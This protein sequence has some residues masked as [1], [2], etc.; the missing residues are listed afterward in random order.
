MLLCCEVNKLEEYILETFSDFHNLVDEQR[1][2]HSIYRGVADESYELISRFGRA[3]IKNQ[4]FREKNPDFKYIVDSNKEIGSLSRLKNES[5]PY[6]THR[7][8]NDWEWLS[9]AQHHGL[10]TRLLDWTE[11]PL[12]A[13]YF[14]TPLDR[15]SDCGS[16]IYVIPEV[17]DLPMA[18]TGISPFE[19]DEVH[20][21]R[22]LHIT[23]RLSA[24]SGLFTFHPSPEETF[25]FEAIKKW[26]IPKE[27][28]SKARQVV[29][30]YGF[31]ALSMF[32]GLDGLCGKITGDWG[33][34]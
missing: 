7:P 2:T 19:I 33:L 34:D 9:L 3:S 18:N 12:V 15:N 31:N 27:L 8:E 24:Q 21:H 4:R 14:A 5:L 26:I 11:N 17:H 13:L 1:K 22:P 20:C 23:P 28:I 30:R 25:E 32:P 6:L 10:P 29:N 16:A